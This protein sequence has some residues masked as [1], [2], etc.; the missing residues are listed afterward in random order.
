MLSAVLRVHKQF[1]AIQRPVCI[2]AAVV[3]PAFLFLSCT[4]TISLRSD[5][6]GATVFPID[7]QG[8]RAAP[9]GNT[10]LSFN[11]TRMAK[12]SAVELKREGYENK[13]VVVPAVNAQNVELGVKLAPIDETWIRQRLQ[14]EQSRILSTQFM[15]LLKLQNAILQRSD[16][17]VSVLEDSMKKDFSE[18]S[19]WHS[20]LGNYYFLKGNKAK[21]LV[22][23]KRAFEL[24]S[25]N[26]EAKNMYGSLRKLEK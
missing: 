20:M 3:L 4:H 17:E 19:A 11:S 12:Y 7:A 26:A 1:V 13:I 16:D 24:D 23:Y 9:L 14:K 5:P 22:Y 15:E 25:N 21:A 2:V 8:R 10:P 6:P 18:I